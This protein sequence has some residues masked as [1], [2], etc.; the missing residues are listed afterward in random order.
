M[1]SHV[2]RT[3]FSWSIHFKK[4]KPIPSDLASS[5]PGIANMVHLDASQRYI[6]QNR[7]YDKEVK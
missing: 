5:Q 7:D 3:D 4:E 6:L 1:I 2:E